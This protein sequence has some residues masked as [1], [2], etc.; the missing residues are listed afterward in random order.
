ML[1]YDPTYPLYTLYRSSSGLLDF[2]KELNDLSA[3]SLNLF[4]LD[5]PRSI[6]PPR[7]KVSGSPNDELP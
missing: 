5:Y 1:E 7:L 6:S 4:S 2:S 3:S